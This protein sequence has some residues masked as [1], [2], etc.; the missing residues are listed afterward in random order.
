MQNDKVLRKYCES[1]ISE[2]LL[3]V[4]QKGNIIETR[5]EI[6]TPNKDGTLKR[7]VL[8]EQYANV[9]KRKNENKENEDPNQPKRKIKH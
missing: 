5:R 8:T 4:S 2:T 7:S 1:N 6:V 9:S 3:K